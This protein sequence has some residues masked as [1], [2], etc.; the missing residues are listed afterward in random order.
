[1]VSLDLWKQ[2][3]GWY[4]EQ[5]DEICF[6]ELGLHFLVTSVISVD[7]NIGKCSTFHIRKVK[8]M[9]TVSQSPPYITVLE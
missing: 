4:L 7:K 1:M 2:I 5:E 3:F 6:P 8:H 9:L